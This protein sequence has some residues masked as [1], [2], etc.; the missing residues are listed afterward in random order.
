MY[1]FQCDLGKEFWA[2]SVATTY[3]LVNRSPT[4]SIECKT[5]EEVWSCKMVDYSRLRVF[6]YPAYVHMN[7]GKLELRAKKCVFIRYSK[8]V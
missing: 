5:L 4:T 6:G 7:E 8:N 2:K 3:Y 1:I